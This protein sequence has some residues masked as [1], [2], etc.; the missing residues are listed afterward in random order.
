MDWMADD[1]SR[2]SAA[3]AYYAVFSIAPLLV[4]IISI[5]GFVFGEDAARGQVSEQVA[6]LVGDES[7]EMIEG[8]VAATAQSREGGIW[9][10]SV[11]TFFLLFG[12]S[13]VFGEMKN[14]LNIIW[15]VKPKPG[16]A[17]KKMLRERFLSFSLI[18][19]I[20]FLLLVSLAV[21]AVLSGASTY[22]SEL[23]LLPPMLWR[24][25]DF[26]ISVAVIASLFAILFKALP[27]VV[28]LWR[29]V[30]PGA[31][32]TALLFVLGKSGLA[33]YLGTAGLASSYGAAG[34]LVVVLMWFY[35][36]TAILF[37][38]A[39]LVKARVQRGTGIQAKGHAIVM[40]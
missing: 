40:G 32:I 35:Y 3:L 13:R 20:G 21:S 8:A 23:F 17:I 38:G 2:L 30:L 33:W 25:V 14:S 16:R 24:F 36:A 34:S 5:I 27:D 9:A 1:A 19:G 7:A 37:F 31:I 11:G 12:A 15:G 22:L 26:V 4:I 18:L 6:G 10:M 39:E 28:L 29:D